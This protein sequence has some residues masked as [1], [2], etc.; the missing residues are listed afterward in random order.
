[1]SRGSLLARWSLTYQ[2]HCSRGGT[3]CH[4]YHVLRV[5][6]MSQVLPTLKRSLGSPWTALKCVWS[7][8]EW[9]CGEAVIWWGGNIVTVLRR[10][11][12]SRWGT[13][14]A[15]WAEQGFPQRGTRWQVHTQSCAGPS[16]QE[17]CRVGVEIAS[18]CSFLSVVASGLKGPPGFANHSA[19]NWLS[20][21]ASKQTLKPHQAPAV[22][23]AWE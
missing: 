14:P 23:E 11:G 19:G 2:R 1:M 22:P 20:P 3:V 18:H 6:R 9:L 21:R 16:G 4:C 7:W 17:I 8:G 15:S 5:P 12:D 10:C 13:R